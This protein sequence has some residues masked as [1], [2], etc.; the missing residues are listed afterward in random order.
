MISGIRS[1]F[2]FF[3]KK[4]VRKKYFWKAIRVSIR[5]IIVNRVSR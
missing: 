3:A 2:F 5:K 1:F 4:L